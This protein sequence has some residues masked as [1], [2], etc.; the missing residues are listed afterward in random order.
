M[1]TRASGGSSLERVYGLLLFLYPPGFR[2]EYGQELR[3]TFS[4][5]Y[6]VRQAGTAGLLVFL[7]E[8]LL[9]LAR[10]VPHQWAGALRRYRSSHDLL[11]DDRRPPY[12]AAF[13][14]GL[15]VFVL[16]VVTLAPSIGFWDSGEY[17]AVAHTLGIPHP[18]GSSL[19]VLLAHLWEVVLAPTG[20]TPVVSINL[21]S[22]FLSAGSHA[23]WFLVVDRVLA[24]TI[25]DRKVRWI[26]AAAAVA[27]SATAFTVWNQSNVSEKVYA[28]SF[29]TS[30]LVSWLILRWRDTGCGLRRLVTIVF[31]VALTAT[32]HL[33]GVLVVP[34]LAA[35]VVL[36]DRRALKRPTFWLVALPVVALALS[37][38]L[39]LPLRAAQDPILAE[40]QPECASIVGAVQSIYTWGAS[41][42][43]ALSAVLSRDQYGKPPLLLDPTLYPAKQAPRS[44][45]LIGLQLLNYLQYFDWQ[46]GR[47]LAGADPLFGG[48]RP[49]LTVL[50]VLLGLFGARTNWKA[51]RETAIY[52]GT[53]FL[54]LSLGLVGYLNFRYGF[55][56]AWDRFPAVSMHEVRERD[57]F[58]VIGFSVWG[59]WA[60]IGLVALWSRMAGIARAKVPVPRL[61]TSPVLAL[62]VIPLALNWSWASRADDFAARDFAYNALMSVEPYGVLVTNGDNDTFPLWYLQE[63][64]GLRRDVTVMVSEYL[65]TSWYVKQL[66]QLTEP[67]PAGVDPDAT[68]TRIVC[69]RAMKPGDLPLPLARAGWLQA[70][71]PPPDSIFPLSDEEI[72]T[73]AGSYFVT[74][75]PMTLRAGDI[76]ATIASGTYLAPADTFVATMLRSTLGERPVHF[77]PGSSIVSTL[78]IEDY[79]IRQGLTWKIH[80]GPLPDDSEDGVVRIENS[81][82]SAIAGA[83]IDLPLTDTLLWDVYIRRGRILK[84]DA[85]WADAASSGIPRQYAYAHYVAG[86]THARAGERSEMDRHLRR[87]A[88]WWQV[89]AN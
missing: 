42:C 19:F 26:G 68:P 14:A 51:D 84:Q 29:F 62:A 56:I 11:E 55:A 82:L 34:A 3:R 24:G 53:L 54:T 27:L 22:A 83:A 46:W 5:W 76:E 47:G 38:Q 20:L 50:F 45:E 59:L 63:V 6:R 57:Y 58:F 16:Y 89:A 32:N 52:M 86:E 1:S 15:L 61:A 60:G 18:P 73:I 39:L 80:N 10:S 12:A 69:Q 72:E 49:A 85:P 88:W 65:N 71:E 64:E 40:G 81:Q 74:D 4:D 8:V 36:V 77:M 75:S 25:E 31:V 44:A 13:I 7:G 79:A 70:T 43:D 35:F 87:A 66:R 41:G 33:M 30:A 37:T 17:T 67:C 9:D 48:M 78:G 28:V 2:N 23:L 21:F